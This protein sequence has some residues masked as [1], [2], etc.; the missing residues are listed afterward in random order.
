M[1]KIEKVFALVASIESEVGECFARDSKISDKLV[2]RVN[3]SSSQLASFS[4]EASKASVASAAIVAL[5]FVGGLINRDIEGRKSQKLVDGGAY[6]MIDLMAQQIALKSQLGS[7]L[8]VSATAAR[9]DGFLMNLRELIKGSTK[10]EVVAVNL[11]AFGSVAGS[12]LNV[13]EES[14]VKGGLNGALRSEVAAL[15]A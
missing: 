8:E 9:W 4:L 7:M 3:E 15:A 2:Q 11:S 12:V 13:L 14:A 6:A 1:S 5:G 10:L